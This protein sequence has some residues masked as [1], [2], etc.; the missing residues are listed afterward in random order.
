MD[1]ERFDRFSRLFAAGTTRRSALGVLAGMAGLGLREAGARRRHRRRNGTRRIQA[2]KAGK[3][4]V[5]HYDAEAETWH[6]ISI[7]QR[8]WENGH[9]KHERDFLRTDCCRDGDC[10]DGH[11]CCAGTCVDTQTDA[12]NC[13]GCNQPCGQDQTCAA[14]TC[15]SNCPPGTPCENPADPFQN[16]VCLDDG[17]CGLIICDEHFGCPEGCQCDHM[18]AP[19]PRC[20]K[21]APDSCF[22]GERCLPNVDLPCPPGKA[23]FECM[24]GEFRCYPLCTG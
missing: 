6:W 1:E 15:G 2:T 19:R 24:E 12:D 22:G 7:G 16:L 18:S 3:V 14:G 9:A 17:S 4:D 13:G 11:S 10:A 23:C 21:S 5:C 20:V 8:G